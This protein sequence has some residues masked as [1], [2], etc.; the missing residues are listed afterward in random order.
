MEEL[1]VRSAGLYILLYEGDAVTDV[2]FWGY[3]GD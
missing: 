3:S 2:G 1:K